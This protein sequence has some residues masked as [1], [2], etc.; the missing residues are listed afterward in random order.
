MLIVIIS[1]CLFVICLVVFIVSEVIENTT[2]RNVPTS[3]ILTAL[4]LSIIF[5]FV[6]LV[7]GGIAIQTQVTKDV[8][9]EQKIYEKQ[10]LE[11]RL[12][13]CEDLQGNELLYADITKFNNELRNTKH[14][15]NNLW[16]SWFYN[17]KVATIDYIE[18]GNIGKG[19]G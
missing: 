1:L 10:V 19:D 8:E 4:L 17:D 9:Y 2:W 13:N 16:T 12:E 3:L 7:S 6:S 15:A 11:Y 14:W 18:I 5:G